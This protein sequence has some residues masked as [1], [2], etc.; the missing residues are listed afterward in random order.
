MYH[1]TYLSICYNLDH[2]E[3]IKTLSEPFGT[4]YLFYDYFGPIG[5]GWNQL[6]SSGIN[7]DHLG[8]V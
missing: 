7:W 4:F 5:T 3:T 1:S 6:G 2:A 8:P